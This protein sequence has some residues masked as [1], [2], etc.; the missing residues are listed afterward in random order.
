MAAVRV[1]LPRLLAELIGGDRRLTVEA[2]S[3]GSALRA[4]CDDHPELA[5][6]LFDDRGELRQ[7]VTCLRN[8]DVVRHA[9]DTRVRAGD[10][11]TVLQAVSGG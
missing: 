1:S 3:V 6:H 11:V 4:A 2:D 10:E 8:G 9:L 7:H 5:V